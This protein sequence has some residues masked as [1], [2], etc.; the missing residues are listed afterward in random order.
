MAFR[1]SS[2]IG[3][4]V[5]D[6]PPFNYLKNP[7]FCCKEELSSFLSAPDLKAAVIKG[8][9]RNFCGGADF[10]IFREQIGDAKAFSTNLNEGKELLEII[11]QAPVPVAACIKIS[12]LSS[13]YGE[14][15]SP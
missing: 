3:T 10:E 14:A 4:M 5:I 8:S 2:G 13:L 9:G 7:V 11:R 15:E 6:N 12:A 1:D